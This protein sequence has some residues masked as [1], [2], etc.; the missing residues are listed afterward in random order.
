VPIRRHFRAYIFIDTAGPR[1]YTFFN[2]KRPVCRNASYTPLKG[3]T[4]MQDQAQEPK[5]KSSTGL[6][7]NIA[8]PLCYVLG[9]I[10]GLIFFLVEKESKFVKFHAMQSIVASGALTLI[11]IAVSIFTPSLRM[12]MSP[13]VSILSIVILIVMIIK[14]YNGEMYKLP[15]AGDIA[16]KQSETL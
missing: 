1:A 4:S 2:E 3:E 14:A 8:G 6:D 12:V 11:S 13:L 16:E 9:W 5:K 15:I 7:E 10:T